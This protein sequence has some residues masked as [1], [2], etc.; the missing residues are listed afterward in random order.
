MEIII[1]TV[2]FI[3]TIVAWIVLPTRSPRN[4]KS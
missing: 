2:F 3:A 1:G 4:P